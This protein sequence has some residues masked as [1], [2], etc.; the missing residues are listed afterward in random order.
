MKPY[1]RFLP[2]EFYENAS[3]NEIKFEYDRLQMRMDES[4][5]EL[6]LVN[7]LKRLQ[8]T[9]TLACWHDTSSISNA[10]HFLVLI[11][12]VYAEAVFYT[13]DEYVAKTGI[14]LLI[15]KY[16]G[17]LC[18]RYFPTMSFCCL[19]SLTTLPYTI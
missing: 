17:L 9:R 18:R 6:D 1:L 7:E 15:Q 11:N 14:L 12:C 5:E 10:S 4:K 16:S 19:F 13:H 3:K 2:N 8:R